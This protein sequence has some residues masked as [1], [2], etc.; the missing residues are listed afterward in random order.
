MGEIKSALELALEKTA[1]IKSDPQ[2]VKNHEA[3]ERGKRLFARLRNEPDLDVRKEITAEDKTLRTPLKEG[4][5]EV[6]SANLVLPSDEIGLR[7]LELIEKALGSVID[8]KK[9]LRTLMEQVH[10]F[11][12]QH[13]SD[14]KQLIE[15]LRRQYEPRIRERERQLAQQLGRPVTLDPASDPEFVKVLQDNLSKLQASYREPFN[16]VYEQLKQMFDAGR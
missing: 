12:S 15:G 3:R 10:Q 2:A 14:R 7:S 16:Q 8:N 4:F 6:V 13:L 9:M 11:F 5:F 1:S